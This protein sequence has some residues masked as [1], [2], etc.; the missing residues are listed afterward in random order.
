MCASLRYM[1]SRGRSS[2][3]PG[4]R[5]TV[6]FAYWDGGAGHRSRVCS[7]AETMSR[8]GN[9]VLILAPTSDHAGLRQSVFRA[10]IV[11]HDQRPRHA[12]QARHLQPRPA[13]SHA[14]GHGQRQLALGFDDRAWISRQVS[15]LRRIIRRYKPSLIVNDYHDLVYLAARLEDVPVVGIVT[16]T[17]SVGSPHMGYWRRHELGGRAVPS[18][19]ATLSAVADSL[20]V[21]LDDERRTFSGDVSLLASTRA[22]DPSPSTAVP[23]G[24]LSAIPLST[25][26]G[27]LEARP[28]VVVY[29]GEANNR[30]A[31]G[32]LRAVAELVLRNPDLEF[33]V[34]GSRLMG[35]ALAERGVD[36]SFRGTVSQRAFLRALQSSRLL[37]THGG[38]SLTQG[39]DMGIPFV[40]LPWSS[41]ETAPF[42]GVKLGAGVQVTGFERALEWRF[43][44]DVGTEV[45][46]IWEDPVTAGALSESVREVLGG[47]DYRHVAQQLAVQL[48]CLGAPDRAARICERVAR[49]RIREPAASSD[50]IR[51]LHE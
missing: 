30:P 8:S 13:Y 5:F 12:R 37:V 21:H 14:F 36:A 9:R 49:D 47:A 29:L 42:R 20:G 41:G 39:L 7:I 24:P 6:L 33:W 18:N 3:M 38:S 15:V 4:K 40:L 34:F 17:G 43:D 22:L 44:P 45:S 25:V 51:A 31:G 32:R 46:G 26:L 19:F 16:S 50:L 1:T 35:M 23:V 11:L 27:R 28:R 10:R 2:P 48:D